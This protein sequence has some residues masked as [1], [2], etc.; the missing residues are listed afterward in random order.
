MSSI[1]AHRGYWKKPNEQNTYQAIQRAFEKGF[2]VEVDVRFFRGTLYLSHDPITNEAD[3]L[4]VEE[5]FD[6]RK[7]KYKNL[8]IALNVK[9]SGVGPLLEKYIFRSNWFVFDL[10]YPD[11]RDYIK[12]RLPVYRRLSDE[13]HDIW[14]AIGTWIDVFQSDWWVEANESPPLPSV[15]VSPELHNRNP[16]PMWIYIKQ[17]PF[18]SR[19]EVCT[20]YPEECKRVIF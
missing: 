9:D 16:L 17:L 3:L 8:T 4:T 18:R 19:P 6:M 5:V 13:E 15:A 10:A 7:T 1:I 12:R 2:G 20:D 11:A 14:P